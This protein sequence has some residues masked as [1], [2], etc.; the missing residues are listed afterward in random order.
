MSYRKIQRGAGWLGAWALA[1][2]IATQVTAAWGGDPIDPVPARYCS[3]NNELFWYFQISDTH[4]GAGSQDDAYLRWAVTEA[5]NV[6]DPAFIVLTGD[7]TDSTNCD[8]GE[9]GLLRI[10]DG[11]HIEE[12]QQ[13][14]NVLCLDCLVPYVDS[15]DFFDLPGNHDVYSDAS[16]SF[17]LNNSVQGRATGSTQ[18]SWTRAYPFGKYHFVGL[19][20]AANDGRAF[21]IFFPYGDRAGLDA[22]ELTFIGQELATH[23]DAA[24]TI[25]FGHHPLDETGVSGDTWILY[26]ADE[27]AGLMNN[28][29]V[30]TY[31][32]GHTHRYAEEFFTEGVEYDSGVHYAIDPANPAR[33][34]FYFNVNSLGKEPGQHIQLTAI[35]CNGISTITRNAY[36]W[37]MVMITAPVDIDLGIM[38]TPFYLDYEVTN[39]PSNPIRALAFDVGAITAVQY[40]IDGVGEWHNLNHLNGPLWVGTWDASGLTEGVHSIQ[41][42]A[43]AGAATDTDTIRVY[44]Q[45]SA[46]QPPTA[47]YTY[48]CTAL[49]CSFDGAGSSDPDGVIVSYEWNFGD[50]NTGSGS[51]ASHTYGVAGTYTVQLTVTDDDGATDIATQAVT[52]SQPIVLHVGDLDGSSALMPRGR[53]EAT[54]TIQVHDAHEKTVGNATI[55]GAWSDGTSGTAECA[56]GTNGA[57]SVAKGNL[58]TNLA[59]VRF[60]VSAVTLASATYDAAANQDPDGDSDGS[61]IVVYQTSAP[62]NQPPTAQFSYS[63]TGLSCTFDG[64]GSSDVD[65]TLVSYAWNFGDG[66]SGPGVT[67]VHT[68]GDAGTYPVELT[69]T[70]DDGATGSITHSVSVGQTAGGTLHVGDL[71]GTGEIVSRDRWTVRVTILVHDENHIATSDATVAGIWIGGTKGGSTCVTGAGGTCTVEKANLKLSSGT[72]TFTVDSVSHGTLTYTAEDN[73]DAD[74]DSNGTAIDIA[75]P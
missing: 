56:T 3:Q 63:C 10:P 20:T 32:Y 60:T 25:L 23:S 28:Y 59:S 13:Y 37:P 38:D 65:G 29:G 54:V 6:I 48:S 62:A 58:K 68:Y 69:V 2:A 42:Q 43:A 39:V 9:C 51:P 47:L 17:Y 57:C 12:W 33:G 5:K 4:I 41:V 71:E 30:S 75:P 7:I 22:S 45:A 19:D 44:V 70:D 72:V 27:L 53:W 61:T 24:V 67:A 36:D 52:A 74:G 55:T 21:S 11:P 18:A 64:S 35:D 34:V 1:G 26:G 14:R 49:A 15:A 73:H 46:N 50:G 40:R 8:A 16:A 66:N 31:G